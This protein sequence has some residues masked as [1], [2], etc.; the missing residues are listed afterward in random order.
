VFAQRDQA[1]RERQQFPVRPVPVEPGGFV[2]LR[3]GVVVAGLRLAKLRAHRQHGRSAREHQ[4]RQQ[5]ALILAARREDGVV[6]RYAF[7][8]IVP[9]KILVRPVAVVFAIG[10]VA[11][12]RIRHKIAQCE[13]VM[14]RDEIYA[15]RGAAMRLE[16]IP[17]TRD[18]RREFANANVV[19]APKA[20]DTI[21]EAIVPLREWP[22]KLAELVAARTYVPR[23]GDEL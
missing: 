11:F 2:V 10:V 3:I 8:S 21:A 23:L 15:S 14:R 19:A 16:E 22:R 20:P 17:R 7:D 18:A 13:A 4:T 12:M 5:I 9:G 1:P 6:V